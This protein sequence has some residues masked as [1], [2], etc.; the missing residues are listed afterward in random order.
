VHLEFQTS[1]E[2]YFA[3]RMLDYWSRLS[4]APDLA[5]LRIEQHAVVLGAGLVDGSLHGHR[6]RFS[7]EVHYL[8][9]QPVDDLLANPTLAPFAALAR[10]GD[11]QRGEVLRRA[12]DLI[13][14]VGDDHGRT[15]LQRAAMDLARLR[16]DA[17]TID[18]I[19]KESAMPVPSWTKQLYDEGLE[20]AAGAMLRL[21][22]G[23]DERVPGIARHLV[24]L[25]AD[26]FVARI[27]AAG[28]LDELVEGD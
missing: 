11:H 20:D 19:W 3:H 26:E 1:A 24:R 25:G 23:D 2:R 18:S 9:D 22:F 8:R 7:F 27:E 15:V 5:G 12:L 17:A 4:R 21:R 14:T 6:L 28:S 13:V 16:L 10:V